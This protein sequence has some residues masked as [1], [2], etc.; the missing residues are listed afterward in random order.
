MASV[1][2]I[3]AVE[4]R[5][6]TYWAGTYVGFNTTGETPSDGSA[7]LTIQFP[8][9]N[10]EQISI[11][12]PGAQLF[13][14]EGGI[15]FVYATPRGQGVSYYQGLLETLLGHFRATKFSGV[16]T[17]APSTPVLDNAADNGK[18]WL[19]TAAVPYTADTLG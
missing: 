3:A 2:A 16:Q 11:G 8:L 6:A 19:L 4:A 9:A 10:A 15:R 7:F 5:I 14:E 13:R 1:A 17:F 18:Y 12:T